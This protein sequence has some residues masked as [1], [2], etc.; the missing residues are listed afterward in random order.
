MVTKETALTAHL[1]DGDSVQNLWIKVAFGCKDLGR[2]RLRGLT[3][4]DAYGN[5]RHETPL[6]IL[7]IDMMN[8]GAALLFTLGDHRFMDMVAIHAFAAE[9]G[10][11][12]RVDVDHASAQKMV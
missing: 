8:G 4:I 11:Q 9:A 7:F 5:L 3:G 10:Q 2:Q 6:I 1:A 12:C